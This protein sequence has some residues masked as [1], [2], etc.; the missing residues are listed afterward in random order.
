MHA[1]TLDSF[2]LG[3]QIIDECLV[4]SVACIPHHSDLNAIN[5]VTS[6]FLP[7]KQLM[8]LWLAGN[9][10]RN[11]KHKILQIEEINWLNCEHWTRYN[12]FLY[13]LKNYCKLPSLNRKECTYQHPLIHGTMHYNFILFSPQDQYV[14]CH[15]VLAD[16]MDK[17]E[18]YSNFKDM[19]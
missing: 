13:F 7:H 14:F 15:E 2:K 1:I 12:H 19:I 5:A 16:Y 18:H 6:L 9:L 4:V 8:N 3:S 10:C 11:I 17:F